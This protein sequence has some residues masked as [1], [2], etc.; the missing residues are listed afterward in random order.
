MEQRTLHRRICMLNPTKPREL[1]NFQ[2]TYCHVLH[3]ISFF[4]GSFPVSVNFFRQLRMLGLSLPAA[5]RI[6][7]AISQTF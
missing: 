2:I 4:V 1:T 7:A 3:E 5:R 6:T